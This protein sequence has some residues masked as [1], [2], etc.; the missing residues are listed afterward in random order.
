[1]DCTCIRYTQVPKTSA[2]FL[3]YLYH[4]DRVAQ[5]YSG[6][7]FNLESYT[8]VAQ[9]LRA[10]AGQN[11]NELAEILI[12]QNEELGCSERTRENIVKLR[13]QDAFAVLT[14]QQVGLFSGPA[15]TIYKALTAVRVAQWLS[16]EGMPS[17]PAFW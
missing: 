11:R 15:F 16:D 13:D 7:P 3:D 12:R 4:F 10:S 17:V 6:S 5:F 14:G 2:L 9:Q 8:A 1:M